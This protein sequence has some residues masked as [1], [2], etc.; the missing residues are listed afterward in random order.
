MGNTISLHDRVFAEGLSVRSVLLGQV[1]LIGDV[2]HNN[3]Y[4]SKQRFRRE[5]ARIPADSISDWI[6]F[7]GN[8][9]SGRFTGE[10][11]EAGILKID[12]LL[13]ADLIAVRGG[14][15]A[16]AYKRGSTVMV[17]YAEHSPLFSIDQQNENNRLVAV[18]IGRK[19]LEITAGVWTWENQFAT[20]P[21]IA[22]KGPRMAT[23]HVP[24]WVTL[25]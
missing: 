16:I 7:E 24:T 1:A 5:H 23:G 11:M 15:Q 17:G 22:T 12:G 2:G 25:V 20:V 21:G 3:K 18:G 14:R 4:P 13:L 6:E 10:E 8:N 19:A 9:K